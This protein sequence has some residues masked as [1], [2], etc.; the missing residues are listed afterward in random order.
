MG[1]LFFA[2]YGTEIYLRNVNQPIL[3]FGAPGIQ[4]M[5]VI[6]LIVLLLFGGM[7][8]THFFRHGL[9]PF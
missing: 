5:V 9:D 8:N 3:A 1:K 4:E 2:P 7:I 6:F